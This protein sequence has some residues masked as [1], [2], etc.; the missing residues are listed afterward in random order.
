MFRFEG[1][2]FAA[3]VATAALADRAVTRP[4]TA[5]IANKPFSCAKAFAGLGRTSNAARAAACLPGATTV[6]QSTPARQGHRAA[7]QL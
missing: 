6:A 1:A 5:K 7:R 2:A 4:L 3:G